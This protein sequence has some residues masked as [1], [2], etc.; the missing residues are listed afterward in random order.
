MVT[1]LRIKNPPLGSYVKNKFENEGIECFFT[2][3]GLI[4]GSQ[5]NP[6][7]VLLK[8]KAYQSEK[9]VKILLQIH[10]DYGLDK[11]R[12]DKTFKDLKKILVPIKLGEG[13][14]ELI[15]YAL[16][17]AKKINAEIKLLYVYGDPTIAE[18]K[19]HTASWEKH[20]KIELREAHKKAQDKLV[21]FSVELKK[22]IPAELLA[23]VKLHYRMLKGMPE[24]VISDA[25]NRYQPDLV[26][27]GTGKPTDENDEFLDKT[28]IKVI[29]RSNYPVL[30]VPN[31][32]EFHDKEKLN[33]MYATD[34]YDSDNSS[35]NKLL[36][37]LQHFEKEIQCIHV[38]L[39][40]DP[41]HQKKVDQLN[42]M[43]EKE[44]ANYHIQCKLFESN[45]VV[46]GFIEFVEKN[47]V[48]L[49]SLS[50]QRRSAFY[51]MF[52]SNILGKL[53]ITE[54]VPILIFPV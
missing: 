53:I 38:D 54:K 50:K 30:A 28:V 42:E 41:N 23:S 35:L 10:K 14:F 21:D 6:N 18:N 49:I 29:E 32:A 45:D 12:E 36:S 31:S 48:D 22:K 2:N 16:P 8:V 9:A 47:N 15:H 24:F 51:K 40:D 26:L 37:I 27:M 39:N 52:H 19:K 4:L 20:V 3:E 17:L 44:Y 1:I 43:L 25:C 13:S 7:E 46:K 5:Y 33:V 34:F 11:I